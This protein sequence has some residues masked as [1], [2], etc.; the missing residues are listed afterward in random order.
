MPDEGVGEIISRR[1]SDFALL[2]LGVFHNQYMHFENN[3]APGQRVVKV[4]FHLFLTDFQYGTGELFTV[5][6]GETNNL[7]GLEVHF[8]REVHFWQPAYSRVIPLSEGLPRHQRQCLPLVW[9]KPDKRQLQPLI[10]TAVADNESLRFLIKTA[11]HQ[12]AAG[13]LD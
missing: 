2:E 3:L 10:H 13:E 6:C 4:H 5:G 8:L 11:F 1:C 7:S 9:A 12:H